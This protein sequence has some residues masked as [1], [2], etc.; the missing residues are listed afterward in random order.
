MSD[1]KTLITGFFGK[2]LNLT[3][4]EVATLLF[5][6][7]D[8]GTIKADAL[9]NLLNKDTSR[10]QKFKDE[11]QVYHDNG[12]KKAQKE[13]LTKLEEQIKEAFEISSE[14]KGIDLIQEIV[15]TK[16]SS[17]E[18]LAEE[19]V[20]V[21]PTFTKTVNELNKKIKETESAWKDKYE[22][23]EK[24]LSKQN[25]FQ[26]VKTK[27]KNILENL[28]P[29]LPSDNTKA[30]KQLTWFFQELGQFEFDDQDGTILI[31]KDGKLLEDGHGNRINF[32]SFIKDKA[33]SIWDF[34]QGTKKEGTGNG[35]DGKALPADKAGSS[36]IKAP[37]DKTE[38]A[39][40]IAE[41]KTPEE[42]VEISEVWEKAQ[43]TEV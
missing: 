25:A 19:K 1:L 3:A 14:S 35:K 8:E 43:S 15:N 22:A 31:M 24:D 34:Q 10:I 20:K 26:G 18:G 23:R 6:N 21:H 5:E 41:A 13:A 27:A 42:R 2:T 37:K 9:D 33:A 17:T 12:Y 39:R 40:M 11:R 36:T 4:D 7:V 16:V 30:E 29:I 38:F 32:D 28:K